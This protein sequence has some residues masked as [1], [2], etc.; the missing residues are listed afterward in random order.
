MEPDGTHQSLV[1]PSLLDEEVC[2]I[3]ARGPR[4]VTVGAHRSSFR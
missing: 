2:F 3:T 1:F 4:G